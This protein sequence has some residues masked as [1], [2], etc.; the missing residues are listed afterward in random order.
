[1]MTSKQLADLLRQQATANA[2]RITLNDAVLGTSGID[3]LVK[4]DLLRQDGTLLLQVDPATIPTDPPAGG[5]SLDAAVPVGDAGFLHLDDRKAPITFVVGGTID[6]S[7]TVDTRTARSGGLVPWV[8]S[9][10]FKELSYQPYDNLDL[11]APQLDFSTAGG[12]GLTFEGQL[13]LTGFFAA[14]ATLM[15]L[16]GSFA[17]NGALVRADNGDL[18]F[19]LEAGLGL[20][21]FGLGSIITLQSPRIGVS[22][23]QTTQQDGTVDLLV[24]LYLAA[25]ASFGEANPVTVDI[26]MA[27][28][29]VTRSTPILQLSVMPVDYSTSLT[30]LGSLVAGQSWDD[31]FNGPAS[32]LKPY[33]DTFGF[34]GYTMSFSTKG[35]V[36]ALSLSVGTL[37]PWQLWS[38]EYHLTLDGNWSVVFLSGKAI[39]TL[40]L[41]AGFNYED[42]MQFDVTVELPALRISGVQSGDP[43]TLSLKEALDKLFGTGALSVPDDL[44]KISVSNFSIV[45][46]KQA[47]TLALGMVAGLSFSLFGTQLLALKDMSIGVLVDASNPQKKIYTGTIDG[48]ISLGPITAQV[49]AVLSNDPAVGCVFTVHLV[50]ETVGTMLGH[51]IH[52]VDPTF[53]VSFGEPW[54]KLLAISLDAFVLK[55]DI[56]RKSVSIA[57]EDTI[58]LGFLTLTELA[59]TWAKKEQGPSSTRIEISGTFLGVPFGKGSSNPKLSWD[60][61]NENPPAVPGAGDKL[62]DLRYVGVGQHV[63]FDPKWQPVNVEDVIGKMEKLALPA[64][65]SNLPNL[66][67]PDGLRFAKDSSWLVGFDFTVLGFLQ[68]AVVFNDPNLYGI[69]IALSGERAKSFAG[70]KFEILYRKVTDTI[71]VYHIELKLPDA[72]RHLEFGE[73]SLTLPII[74]IDIYTN[75]NFRIDLGFPKGLDFSNSFC[76]Q[77]FPFIG[78]GGFYFALL[79]GDTSSRVPKITNGFFNPVIEFGI[80]L[81]VG[82]GKTIDEGILSGGLSVTVVGIL[83][84]VIGWFD[85]TDAAT[86]K[87]EYY[88]IQGTIAITGR[89]YGSINFAIIQASLSITAYASVSLVIEAHQ[90]IYIAMSVGVSVE[91]SIKIIFFTI[92]CSFS[93]TISASFTIGSAS[94]TPWTL[95]KPSGAHNNQLFAHRGSLHAPLRRLFAGLA[96]HE[97]LTRMA[98]R[99]AAGDVTLQ[100][101]ARQVFTTP[102]AIALRAMPAFTKNDAG[103]AT[104]LLLGIENGISAR[105]SSLAAHVAP[106]V[107]AAAP[108]IADLLEGL[109]R[110]GIANARASLGKPVDDGKVDADD[111]ALLSRAFADDATLASDVAYTGYLRDF[112]D[113]NYRFSLLAP[114]AAE[115]GEDTGVTIFPMPPVLKMTAGTNAPIDF[116]L[117]HAYDETTLAKMRA[118]FELLSVDYQKFVA[119]QGNDAAEAKGAAD[120]AQTPISQVVLEQYVAMQLR[121]A[122]KACGDV[123]QKY[124][125]SYTDVSQ[126]FG[127]AQIRTQLSAP[128]LGAA[129]LVPPNRDRAI[130]NAQTRLTLNGVHH[131]VKLGESF[132]SIATAFNKVLPTNA[133]I[134]AGQIVAQNLDAG[135][136]FITDTP[137]NFSAL[138]WTTLVG[139]T[140]NLILA[141]LALRA[142]P[143]T[144]I[145]GISGLQPLAQ[146]ILAL[147]ANAGLFPADTDPILALSLPIDPALH[148]QIALP[149]G[150]AFATYQ[151]VPED[152][153]MRIAATS[154]IV[155]QSLVNLLDMVAWVLANNPLTVT[156]PN[157]PQPTGTAIQLPPT[158]HA[159]ESGETITSLASRLLT[160]A[161]GVSAALLAVPTDTDLLAPQ[162]MLALPSLTYAVGSAD[163]F[164]SITEQFNL[165]LEAIET[166]ISGATPPPIFAAGASVAVAEITEMGLDPLL[167]GLAATQWKT[168]A[169]MASRFMLA[170]LQLPDPSDPAF[171]KLTLAEMQ[172]PTKLGALSTLPLY[173]L[174]GQQFSIASPPPA[175]YTIA[176]D[177]SVAVSWF[178]L[179]QTLSFGFTQAQ[180]DVIAELKAASFTAPVE[181][182]PLPLFRLTAARSTLQKHL[183]WQPAAL[184][185]SEVFDPATIGNVAGNPDLWLFPESLV[186]QLQQAEN[187]PPCTVAVGTHENADGMTVNPARAFAWATMLRVTVQRLP[188]DEAA[189]PAAATLVEMIGTDDNG[190]ALLDALDAQLQKDTATLYLLYPPDPTS[191]SAGLISD[192][193]T[194]ATTLIQTNLSTLSHSGGLLREGARSRFLVD[195]E[196][197]AAV[198]TAPLTDAGGFLRLLRDGSIVRSGGYYLRYVNANGGQGLPGYLFTDSPTAEL[199]LLVALTSQNKSHASILSFNNCAVV[200]DNIDAATSNVFVEAATWLVCAPSALKDAAA[201]AQQTFGLTLDAAAIATLNADTPQLLRPGVTVQ[202]PDGKGGAKPDTIRIDDTLATLATR[203]G[204]TPATLAAFGSNSQAQIL[205]PTGLA[206]FYP[207]A[208]V[209]TAAIPAGSVG[210]ELTRPNPDPGNALALTAMDGNTVLNELYHMLGH[211]IVPNKTGNPGFLRSGEGIPVGPAQSRP[212]ENGGSAPSDTPNPIWDYHQAISAAPFALQ[213]YGSVSPALPSASSGPYAGVA[214][215][216]SITLELDFHDPYGNALSLPNGG[217]LPQ[218][219][220]YFDALVG[221]G[222]WPSCAGAYALSGNGNGDPTVLLQFSMQMEKYLPTATLSSSRAAQ[223]VAT[224]RKTY[225]RAYYQLAQPDTAFQLSTTL[226]P[227]GN[228]KPVFHDLPITSFREFVMGAWAALGALEGTQPVVYQPENAT[229]TL[230]SVAALYDLPLADLLTA[231]GDALYASL[232]GS[233]ELTVPQLYTTVSGD[234]LTA[235]AKAKHVDAILLA[236]QNPWAALS[237]T[238]DLE[239]PSRPVQPAADASLATL[240][241]AYQ[242]SIS[243]IALAN[244]TAPLTDSLTLSVAGISVTT[245]GDD[246]TSLVK[247]FADA[248]LSVTPGEIAIANQTVTGLFHTPATLTLTDIVPLAGDSLGSLERRFGFSIQTLATANQSLANLYAAGASLYI[249]PGTAPPVPSAGTT[250]AQFA[251]LYSVTPGSLGQALYLDLAPADPPAVNANVV[252]ATTAKLAIP[253]TVTNQDT[254]T[255]APY[256][257]L[258]SDTDIATIAGKFSGNAPGALGTLNSDLAGLFLAG[259]TVRDAA[260]GKTVTSAADST[261]ATLVAAF[262]AEGVTVTPESLA[263]DNAI[264]ANLVRTGGLWLCPPMIALAQ[265]DGKPDTLARIALRYGILTADGQPDAARVAR[266]NA[267][268]LGL[269]AA[270]VSLT[271]EGVMLTTNPNDTLLALAGRFTQPGAPK[272]A[273]EDLAEAFATTPLI[274]VGVLLLPVLVES[275]VGV[276]I[277]PT[278]TSP[279]TRLGVTVRENR[280]TDWIAD[281]FRD[282]AGVANTLFDVPPQTV[283]AGGSEA[284]LSLDTFATAVETALPGVRVAT[285]DAPIETEDASERSLWLVN[286]ERSP[287]SQIGFQFEAASAVR[288]FAIPPL[289]T[290]LLSGA[291]PVTPYVSGQGLV[292]TPKA[293]QFASIDLD[294]W[295]AQFLSAMDMVLSPVYAAPACEVASS[296]FEKILAAKQT[297][298]ASI[299]GRVQYVM[300]GGGPGEYGEADA[301]RADAIAAMQ[302]ALLVSLSSAYTLTSL[303][304]AAVDVSSSYT[305]P[306]LAP[307]LSGKPKL[308]QPDTTAPVRNAS[309]STAKVPLTKTTQTD[310]ALATFL[311]TVQSPARQRNAT[312]DLDYTVTEIEIP[313]GPPDAS[314]Y[315]SSHWLTLV[316]PFQ[317]GKGKVADVTLPIPLRA[318]PL[319]PTLISQAARARYP[320][321]PTVDQLVRWNAEAIYSHQ[322]ADQ[323]TGRLKLAIGVPPGAEVASGAGD[324]TAL[325][326]ALAQFVQV[327]PALQ[328]DLALLTQRTPGAPS[329]PVTQNAVTAF[330]T[331]ASALAT[332]WPNNAIVPKPSLSALALPQGDEIAPGTYLYKLI[333]PEENGPN[334]LQLHLI[335][336]SDQTA[337]LWPNLEVD[338]GGVAGFQPLTFVSSSGREGIYTYPPNVPRG[339]MLKY[340][341]SVDGLDVVMIPDVETGVAVGR[342]DDLIDGQATCALFVYTTPYTD[343]SS[344]LAPLLV[345]D[346]DFDIGSGPVDGLAAAL[347]AFLLALLLRA[348]APNGSQRVLRI[349]GSFGYELTRSS[350]TEAVS[351]RAALQNETGISTFLPIVLVPSIA[352]TIHGDGGAQIATFA[353]NLGKFVADWDKSVQPSHRNA[354]IFFDIR[355]FSDAAT[356]DKPLLELRSVR[357]HLQ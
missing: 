238:V 8:F 324:I 61:I 184:T 62:L 312:V 29:L 96:R 296:D 21:T 225:L 60:P 314:G 82:V 327:Y 87:E 138:S 113:K 49:D 107:G 276:T 229:T 125:F 179:P 48:Q 323:D 128:G 211:R 197:G 22:F 329:D 120:A 278:F 132:A 36:T 5:F 272:V 102:R 336:D 175:G 209:R 4:R 270:G 345:Y 244:P 328:P 203:N 273:V 176:F 111:V 91:V 159:L 245:S 222:Q 230:G 73:V 168:I 182:A 297:L 104:V 76:L 148:P 319:P 44:L 213:R 187:P 227:D 156:D 98:L 141:R 303:V 112:L 47:K 283:G 208:L 354:A 248:G 253:A 110:W 100:W 133:Q 257:A 17:L 330:A 337:R 346:Q 122:V 221:I 13:V 6:L 193:L 134:T 240:A 196:T 231:N 307:R 277:T 68:L 333:H 69:L 357:Y 305:D 269:L 56:T 235:I 188:S 261:F 298:A 289:S 40:T 28:P 275:G 250:L 318:Y 201:Y 288:S 143:T 101:S 153:L 280:Q 170:G 169:P 158:V 154:L 224:D 55:V 247:K 309:L 41:H 294:V 118:Y 266:T 341:V 90:P 300:D 12:K 43:I 155:Q 163:T 149:D 16:S 64:G 14:F 86:P 11:N 192:Q 249:G 42:R 286:F 226:D 299:A 67:A 174:T 205:T 24:Q 109:V 25:T 191:S 306:T 85:P 66:T 3:A 119:Q 241:D 161:D 355:L 124:T 326:I 228:G 71:G 129:A 51:L 204:L 54:D 215:D 23:V 349:A 65:G 46:D 279:I 301:R 30:N 216:A 264:T 236:R 50:N 287:G 262:A 79:N 108:G 353:Q 199:T 181:L 164:G 325:F 310:P 194:A 331:L 217:S 254:G 223:N 321:N 99:L 338:T 252:L 265:N 150:A 131:Q 195:A 260:S 304:Q 72:M 177:Q 172:D 15:N 220:R 317:E 45:I 218:P 121:A 58:D 130:L 38:P 200:G 145:Q 320:E 198:H 10:S 147:P 37:K 344:P 251:A 322:D 285:G 214:P 35:K 352:L 311:L 117:F 75:G 348:A 293:T 173:N 166:A 115:N 33:F 259:A 95:A 274:T 27:A 34:L 26:R 302:Q 281:A 74:V 291:A 189:T 183:S 137:V 242:C 57:Y 84:G 351:G 80:A 332:A 202:V 340:Q 232:F 126:P 267:A 31:F 70:L 295:G 350:L 144:W 78:Y 315:Q 146:A 167:V 97:R 139:E 282:V 237:T 334:L 88:R 93:A 9:T 94:P 316:H 81:S 185:G 140:L 142:A 255:N 53:D 219:M 178:S 339:T 7:L 103:V 256:R 162:A 52:L 123:L 160:S 157:A 114:A 116:S 190:V 1:M 258:A 106:S 342:N 83:E 20:P 77:V 210:F 290:S 18:S 180:L 105:A 19:I 63:G 268:V 92:H 207:G 59:L 243:G 284:A 186:T 335:A 234:T 152:T 206:Q 39:Q 32:E 246:F 313:T 127:L 89:L 308:T 165:T 263:R 233:A 239:A 347:Q 151:T 356:T 2:G 271:F 212:T 292:G 136:L 171:Q 343:F 135:G